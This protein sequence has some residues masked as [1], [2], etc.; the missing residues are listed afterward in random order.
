[1]TKNENKDIIVQNLIDA[2][3]GRLEADIEKNQSNLRM[4]E[5]LIPNKRREL[6]QSERWVIDYKENIVLLEERI[7]LLKG[8]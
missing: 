6:A 3:I 8:K 7:K 2:E 5:R 4:Q 1:M